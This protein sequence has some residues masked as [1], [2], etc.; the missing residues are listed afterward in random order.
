MNYWNATMLYYLDKVK[1]NIQK[2]GLKIYRLSTVSHTHFQHQFPG[3]DMCGYCTLSHANHV[4][5]RAR[6]I[7]N[8]AIK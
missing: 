7:N 6:F 8:L 2:V 1:E 3:G 5:C 4:F